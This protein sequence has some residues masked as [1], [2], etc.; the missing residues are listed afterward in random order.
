MLTQSGFITLRAIVPQPRL[1]FRLVAIAFFI[2]SLDLYTFTDRPDAF[3][4]VFV[5]MSL[6]AVAHLPV[7][8]VGQ[9]VEHEAELGG[10]LAE[11]ALGQPGQAQPAVVEDLAHVEG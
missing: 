2:S 8:H 4:Y 3:I 11:D 5:S 10:L 6:Y 1:L 9:P 7:E